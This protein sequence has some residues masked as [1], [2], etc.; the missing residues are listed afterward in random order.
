MLGTTSG[1]E[2]EYRCREEREERSCPG[3]L[4]RLGPHSCSSSG[5]DGLLT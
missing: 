3:W 4:D 5:S 1:I 2:S